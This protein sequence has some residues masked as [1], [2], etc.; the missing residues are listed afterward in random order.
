M[1]QTTEI[2][3]KREGNRWRVDGGYHLSNYEQTC[4]VVENKTLN[5]KKRKRT[6]AAQGA[7]SCLLNTHGTF[8][9]ECFFLFYML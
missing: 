4:I 5:A 8:Y 7:N 6:V 2:E 3:N 9:H 1:H